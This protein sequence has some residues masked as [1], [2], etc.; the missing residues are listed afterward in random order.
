MARKNIRNRATSKL[1]MENQKKIDKS[2]DSE[3]SK[4]VKTVKG[5][6]S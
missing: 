1:S 6:L 2:V 3:A 5:S 4:A